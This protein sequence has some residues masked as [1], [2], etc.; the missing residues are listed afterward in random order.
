MVDYKNTTE[1][2][3]GTEGWVSF[4]QEFLDTYNSYHKEVEY[5]NR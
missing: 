1:F 5:F 3:P 4:D 2:V